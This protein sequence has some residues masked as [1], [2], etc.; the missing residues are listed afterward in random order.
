MRPD[1]VATVARA[2]PRI[3][4]TAAV[5]VVV[6]VVVTVAA[7]QLTAEE[8]EDGAAVGRA[9]EGEDEAAERAAE[10]EAGH[11]TQLSKRPDQF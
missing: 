1:A 4:L 7:I 8:D 5:V 11:R 9:P 6:V 3:P 10:V 2:A